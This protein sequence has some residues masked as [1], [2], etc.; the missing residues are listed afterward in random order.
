MHRSINPLLHGGLVAAL[1]LAAGPAR[2]ECDANGDP[3][4]TGG[5][6][7]K[8]RGSDTLFDI[9]KEAIKQARL[10]GGGTSPLAAAAKDLH[11]LGTG[12]GN[13]E[14]AMR[15]ALST[16][17]SNG[18]LGSQSIGPMSRNFRPEIIDS[19]STT[20]FPRSTAATCNATGSLTPPGTTSCLLN[21]GHAAWA[22]TSRNVPGL[23]A[24]VFLVKGTVALE[25]LTF[26]T[27]V[28]NTI[29]DSA[30]AKGVVNDSALPINFGS[31]GA[32]NQLTPAI[33]YNSAMSVILSGVDGSG[34]LAACADPRRVRAIQDMA[35]FLGVTTIQ[36][37]IRRDENSGTTDTFKD[38]IMVVRALADTARY[39]YTG[40]RFCN[41]ASI[42]GISSS[43]VQQGICSANRGTVC[44]AD[45]TCDALT[46]SSKC[47]FNLNNPDYDPIRRPCL[48]ADATNAPTSC[49][50]MTTGLRCQ[51]ADANPNCT[52]GFIVALTDT[53]PGSTDITTSIGARVG[54]SGGDI[55]GFAGREAAS[56]TYGT[57]ALAINTHRAIDS[58]VR[59]SDYMLA[60]RLFIQNSFENSVD[61]LDIPTN[62]AGGGGPNG[63][64]DQLL[65]E[66]LLWTDFLTDRFKMD[67]IVR[68]FNF[69][70]CGTFADGGNPDSESNNLCA[71]VPAAATP[72][73]FDPYQPTGA[74]ATANG[75]TP[76]I[77]YQGRVP[78][79]FTTLTRTTGNQNGRLCT[80]ASPCTCS[81]TTPC[82]DAPLI[83][84]VVAANTLCVS[85]NS[86][87][88]LVCPDAPPRP[89]NA[90]CSVNAECTSLV[91]TDKLSH[92]VPGELHGLYCQ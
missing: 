33:N 19:L 39:A 81:P 65:K 12:S 5:I 82:Q 20:Y 77:N 80:A 52:Q 28:D 62:T 76:S 15:T 40:G 87:T 31:A 23:D 32:W 88:G 41:G 36:H 56:S 3:T 48:A 86:G 60:R 92:G 18:S 69:V 79:V 11:Y 67:P 78:T 24:A 14:T 70:R 16:P 68:Q 38:R 53:D 55:I 25:N 51:A 21:K 42:G 83:Q 26:S 91:C 71:S 6:C 64:N 45:V 54:S 57:K 85:G 10:D 27:F 9:M 2:A 46:P 50:D 44:T 30:F 35:G 37:L 43:T 75:G 13:A 66:Q 89:S 34:T 8:L 4:V 7:Y 90:P 22:P 61:V 73:A 74:L 72:K 63:G 49:T 29:A 1:V 59:N 58:K 47:Q 17:G 84:R